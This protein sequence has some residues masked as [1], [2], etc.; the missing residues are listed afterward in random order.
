MADDGNGGGGGG[1]PEP[2][3][4]QIEDAFQRLVASH[5]GPLNAARDMYSDQFRYRSTIRSQREEI[6]DLRRRGGGLQEGMVAVPKDRAALLEQYEALGKSP[7]E[8]KAAIAAGE[9]AA[10]KLTD[11]EWER[12][13]RGIG[14][15][16]G[17]NVDAFLALPGA[18]G[19]ELY[20][21]D[22][23][24]GKDGET[25]PAFFV[26][27]A[28]GKSHPLQSYVKKTWPAFESVLLQGDEGG[29]GDNG[30]PPKLPN[31]QPPRNPKSRNDGKPGTAAYYDGLRE[32]AKER[33]KTGPSKNEKLAAAFGGAST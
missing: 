32:Q 29:T 33:A 18:K 8:A 9:Q 30:T 15:N 21:E 20:S 13:V 31:G 25:E 11:Y 10:S 22:V 1:N 27:D 26:K 28:D 4:A 3:P 24:T 16:A 5:G 14:K 23:P 12:G 7:D 17:L 6:D 19:L 2:T